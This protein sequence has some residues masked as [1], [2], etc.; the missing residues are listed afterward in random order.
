MAAAPA[1]CGVA[2]DVPDIDWYMPSM[3]GTDCEAAALMSTPGAERSGFRPL[4]RVS[5]PMEEKSARLSCLST[6]AM[7]S[8]LSAEPGEP[9]VPAP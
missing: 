9:M 6:A 3:P 5:G 8:A 2:I 4:E 7:V 1:T